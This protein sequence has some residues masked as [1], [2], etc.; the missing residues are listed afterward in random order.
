MD[1]NE[2][3]KLVAA[4]KSSPL[5]I[6]IGKKEFPVASDATPIVEHTKNVVYLN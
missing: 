6:G 5:L 3:G 1:R 2:P 4:R